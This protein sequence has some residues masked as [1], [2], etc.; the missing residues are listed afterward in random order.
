MIKETSGRQYPYGECV[1]LLSVIASLDLIYGREEAKNTLNPLVNWSWNDVTLYC[2][3]Y[4]VPVNPLHRRL[5]IDPLHQ[6][7]GKKD[8]DSYDVSCIL[9]MVNTYELLIIVVHAVVTMKMPYRVFSAPLEF[10]RS[11]SRLSLLLL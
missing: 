3:H 6:F 4:N 5:Y 2:Q 10:P 11:G 8:R 1:V 9:R 7:I